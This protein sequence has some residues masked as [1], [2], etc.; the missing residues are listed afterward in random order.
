MML[1]DS[2]RDRLLVERWDLLQ[3]LIA[4]RDGAATS[5]LSISGDGEE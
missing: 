1:A 3:Q 2:R 5:P 4:E